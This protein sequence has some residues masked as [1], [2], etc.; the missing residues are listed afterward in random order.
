MVDLLRLYLGAWLLGITVF[1]ITFNL[2]P[3]LRERG[4]TATRTLGLMLA[5]LL[6]QA[7]SRLGLAPWSSGNIL[8]ACGLPLLGSLSYR[9]SF[10]T[11]M[12]W[13]KENRRFLFVGEAAAFAVFLAATALTIRNPAI[14]GSERLMDFT[15]LRAVDSA[16]TFPPE[17]L[18]YAG[19]TLNYYWFGHLQAAL[20]GHLTSL[21]PDILYAIMLAYILA[22]IFQ[23]SLGVIYNLRASL[24]QMLLG[25]ALIALAGNLQPVVALLQSGAE[26]P[27]N[28][29][30]ASRVIPGTITEFPFFSLLVGDLHA[31][32]TLLPIFLTYLLLLQAAVGHKPRHGRGGLVLLLN[33]AVA[34]TVLGNPWNIVPM[35]LLFGI[36]KFGSGLQ[37]PWWSLLPAV[38]AAP[39]LLPVTGPPTAIG[40]V[41]T[42]SPLPT[43]LQVWGL[44]LLLSGL[45]LPGF[46]CNPRKALPWLLLP[47]LCLFF[48]VSA[49]LAA[50]LATGVA[51][52][53]CK[54][55]EER[56]WKGLTLSFLALVIL[57]EFIY[58]KDAYGGALQR[59]NTVF[60]FSYAAWPLG[61][62]AMFYAVIH[63]NRDRGRKKPGSICL[64]LLLASGFVYTYQAAADRLAA[65][66]AATGL[67]AFAALAEKH[68]QDAA[69]ITRLRQLT[70]AKTICLESCGKSYS[71]TGRVAAFSGR[72]TLLGWV[73]HEGLWRH[74]PPELKIRQKDIAYIYSG[75]DPIQRLRLIHRYGIRRVIVGDL[76]L[77]KFPAK[78]LNQLEEFLAVEYHNG[79]NRIYTVPT[80][81]GKVND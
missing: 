3:G 53:D 64:A 55:P 29:W 66:P 26:K 6:L 27:F 38:V 78:A 9:R 4:Y 81:S 74:N 50:L 62:G 57:P 54:T 17:D 76:E 43:F 68:P 2:L 67:D 8:L 34:A 25:G 15:I 49:A 72:P 48:S 41:S 23:L 59:M 7:G 60:K 70:P 65:K 32:Y 42:P 18:W 10:P 36:L 13:A 63:D 24:P 20:L 31:H 61:V 45:L 71:R 47:A 39:L 46:S 22:Q 1:P 80:T 58:L 12:A 19:H 56:I 75:A 16:V 77:A 51:G 79:R 73:Q 28:Y 35:L 52:C 5:A 44:P 21:N 40:L 30:S 11:M 69:I 37:L 33:L 14:S